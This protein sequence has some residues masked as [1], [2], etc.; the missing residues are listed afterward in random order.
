ML[1]RNIRP[2]EERMAVRRIWIV[3]LSIALGVSLVACGGNDVSVDTPGGQ[4]DIGQGDGG[5]TVEGPSGDVNIGTGDYPE[6]WPSDFPVPDGADPAY[7][8]GAN[9]GVAVWFASDQS[10][11][12]IKAF[13]EG[14]LP[15]AGYT[16]DST[17]SN[18]SGSSSYT[19]MSVSGNGWTGGIYMGSDLGSIAPGYSG[20][21]AF[22]VT[23]S[24]TA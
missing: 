19:V 18:I 16:I 14:A 20:N 13:Y 11:D 7:S 12:E 10:A 2:E 5:I 6:G 15:A 24:A 1:A 22:W 23:L 4:V 9:D 21:F 3:L 17:V 8:V